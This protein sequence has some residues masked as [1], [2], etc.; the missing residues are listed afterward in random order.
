MIDAAQCAIGLLNQGVSLVPIVPYTKKPPIAFP[1]LDYFEQRVRTLNHNEIMDFALGAGKFGF[2]AVAGVN[3]LVGI[4]TESEA[5]FK[6]LWETNLASS[7]PSLTFTVKTSRGICCWFFDPEADFEN[8]KS[9]I[10]MQPVIQGE[11]IVHNH[12]MQVPGSIHPSGHVYELL[13]TDKILVKPGVVGQIIERLKSLGWVGSAYY[14]TV[15][16][17]DAISFASLTERLTEKDKQGIVLELLPCWRPG[18]R[19]RLILALCGLLIKNRVAKNDA[20]DLIKRLALGANDKGALYSALAK[21]E[22]QY[23]NCGT[24]RLLGY[25]GLVEIKR[26]LGLVQS[27]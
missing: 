4:D 21:V 12:L 25:R 14:G 8:L 1:L 26:E 2:A 10:P 6:T 7:L 23:R 3:K 11:I 5:D 15:S 20:R 9:A 27:E 19:N 13:G 17:M 22:Y 16:A 24:R 18:Y